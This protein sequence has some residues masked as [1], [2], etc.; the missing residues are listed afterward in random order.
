MSINSPSLR[1]WEHLERRILEWA[2]IFVLFQSAEI[3]ACRN[4]EG[5][6]NVFV[7]GSRD[8]PL[9]TI[10]IPTCIGCL[11]TVDIRLVM[12]RLTCKD[13]DNGVSVGA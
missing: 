7:S 1:N 4:F 5:N 10:L 3:F 9:K 6:Q 8:L 13:I 11:V 2:T 12:K